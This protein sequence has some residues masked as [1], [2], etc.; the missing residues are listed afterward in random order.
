MNRV[1]IIVGIVVAVGL[2]GVF[3]VS[4]SDDTASENVAEPTTSTDT[5][6]EASEDKSATEEVAAV[7]TFT[8]EVW[9]DNWFALYVN[10]EKIGEDSVPITTE[11][12]FNK[13]TFTFTASSPLTIGIEAKDFKETDS[14]LE[15]IGEAKQQMGDGGLI[16]QIKD[17]DGNVVAV[18]DDTWSALVVHKAPL[19]KSCE[20]SSDPDTDCKFSISK[21]PAEWF[22]TSY[23]VST[24]DSATEHSEASVGPKDGYNQV[25][26]D[27]SAQLIWGGD[28]EQD[29]TIL[30]RTTIH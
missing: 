2:G 15:Y 7:T 5:I 29:N 28:L 9:A 23:D 25:S 12:S 8:A 11:R 13:E 16:A 6:N 26:W 21:T 14:G 1:V 17:T 3:L 30:F 22:D 24:W 19:D 20:R 27:A 10:G 4:G 18:T